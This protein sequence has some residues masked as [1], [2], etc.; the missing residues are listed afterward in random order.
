M[1]LFVSQLVRVYIVTVHFFTY[2]PATPFVRHLF[3]NLRLRPLCLLPFCPDS[4][5]VNRPTIHQ[6]IN[7]WQFDRHAANP[8]EATRESVTR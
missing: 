5:D 6:G 4:K 1:S 3:I 8:E 7:D 2:L